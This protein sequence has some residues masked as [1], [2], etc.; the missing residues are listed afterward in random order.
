MNEIRMPS[1]RSTSTDGQVKEIREFLY[2]LTNNLNVALKSVERQEENY[3]V[4]MQLIKSTT[5]ITPEEKAA[6][7]FVALKNLIIKS[8][9]IIDCYYDEIATK[10]E[11]HYSAL[12][13]NGQDY[14]KFVEDTTNYQIDA[15]DSNTN[16]YESVQKITAYVGAPADEKG[17]PVLTEDDA[18]LSLI[19]KDTF[20][21][22]TGWVDTTTN[23]SKVGG[24]ELGQMS[25]DGKTTEKAFAK[26]TTQKLAFYG[27]DGTTELGEFSQGRLLVKDAKIQGNLELG[28]YVLDTYIG[29]A[30]KWGGR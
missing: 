17:L 16:V 6:D 27:E 1:I 15:S 4:A 21:I 20:F 10:L 2:Q 11:G 19:R 30:F 13:N 14:A 26:F 8:A 23:G 22:K 18:S 28:G 5:D 24:I 29:I 7:N 12:A 9:D 3:K 25:S